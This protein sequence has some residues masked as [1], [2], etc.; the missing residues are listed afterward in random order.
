MVQLETL[1]QHHCLLILGL[2][3]PIPWRAPSTAV[4]IRS[5]SARAGDGLLAWKRF[6]VFLRLHLVHTIKVGNESG[7]GPTPHRDAAL[8]EAQISFTWSHDGNW[9]SWWF[10]DIPKAVC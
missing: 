2:V 8:H 3:K 9:V 5:I 6:S 4:A 1:Q 7:K 10:T